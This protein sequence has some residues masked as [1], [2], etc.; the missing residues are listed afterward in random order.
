MRLFSWAITCFAVLFWGSAHAEIATADLEIKSIQHTVGASA[1]EC[2]LVVR[3][4]NDDAAYSV[5]VVVLLP[6]HVKVTSMSPAA[7]CTAGPFAAPGS[8]WNGFVRCTLGNISPAGGNPNNPAAQRK[9]G[10]RT[11]LP[12]A[13]P[14]EVSRACAAFVWSRTGDHKRESNNFKSSSP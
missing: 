13:L 6:N 7:S 3:N 11:T 1:Y 12:K 10:I 9:I 2:E 8:P 4:I 5:E 14:P